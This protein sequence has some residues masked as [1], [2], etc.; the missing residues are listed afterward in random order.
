MVTIQR[1]LN[2][3]A[4][5]LKQES[6]NVFLQNN[7]L[8]NIPVRWCSS[9]A[10]ASPLW[11]AIRAIYDYYLPNLAAFLLPWFTSNIVQGSVRSAASADSY[12]LLPSFTVRL[13]PPTI[14]Q[15][16]HFYQKKS[17]R[18]REIKVLH[19]VLLLL[20]L[21]PNPAECQRP[22]A[23]NWTSWG[24]KRTA[25]TEQQLK[26]L[27]LSLNIFKRNFLHLIRT[28]WVQFF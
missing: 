20:H 14:C 3:T 25:K 26:A 7:Y 9:A 15:L 24:R 13:D 6:E 17:E 4:N 11:I 5:G 16:S 22:R 12:H 2:G 8:Q 19:F 10:A 18:E 27:S 21:E 1:T 23:I 28:I